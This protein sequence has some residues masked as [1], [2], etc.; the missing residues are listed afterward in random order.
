MSMNNK[1]KGI[2]FN[3]IINWKKPKSSFKLAVAHFDI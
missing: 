3:N 1:L 2:D